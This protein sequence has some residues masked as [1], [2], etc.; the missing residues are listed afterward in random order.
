MEL[1]LF[2]FFCP[3]TLPLKFCDI[4]NCVFLHKSIVIQNDLFQLPSE[5]NFLFH[6]LKSFQFS[7]STLVAQLVECLILGFS[8]GHD[9]KVL[10]L[11][12]V[13]DSMLSW[14]MA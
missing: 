10:G 3:S 7:C 2:L 5:K 12:P 13:L 14:E 4:H 9:L 8:S 1:S 6:P 11:R